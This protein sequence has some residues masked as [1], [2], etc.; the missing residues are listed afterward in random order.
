MLE[1][2]KMLLNINDNTKDDLLTFLI[3]QAREEAMAYTHLDCVDEL[4]R[5]NRSRCRH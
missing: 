3:E 4:S 2:L 1:N 5:G